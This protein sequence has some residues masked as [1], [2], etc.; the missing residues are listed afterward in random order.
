MFNDPHRIRVSRQD[1]YDKVWSEP[2]TKLAQEYGISDV[3]LA[4]ICRKLDIPYPGRGYWR[5]NQTGKVVKQVPLPLNSDSAKQF[6]T[7]H[8]RVEP[9]PV[10]ELSATMKERIQSE[11]AAEQKIEVLDRLVSPHRLLKGRMT[12]LRSPKVDNYGAIWSGGLRQLN[13]RVSP[14]SLQRALCI[15]NTLFN[16]LEVRGYQLILQEGA[17][18]SLRVCIDGEFIHFGLEEKFQRADHPDRN[19]DRL[20][21]WQRQRY[22]Y[23]P[24]GKLFLKIDE[25]CTQ[26]FQKIWCDGKATKLEACLNGFIVGL[27][28]IAQ[29]VK[30]ERLKREKEHL[31]RLEAEKQRLLEEQRRQQEE[32]RRNYLIQ[33]AAA[34]AQ[35]QQMRAYIAAF[36]IKL[37][38]RHGEIRP[39]SQAD[40]WISWASRQADCLDPLETTAS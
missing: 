23:L 19:N 29:V 17:K 16:A 5:K 32:K 20:Q 24:T 2:M 21:P 40:Q 38:A 36:K 34:W 6:A 31:A 14:T 22:M 25:W 11:V 12:E 37:M 13:L 4:K 30:A 8:W 7:I 26:G 3:A 18:S 35:A 10:E 27:I 33:D 1:L 28:S 15:M 39:G 9:Q